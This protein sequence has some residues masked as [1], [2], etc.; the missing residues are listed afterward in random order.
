MII[1]IYLYF[2]NPIFRNI[3]IFGKETKWELLTVSMK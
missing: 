1:S 3:S 2:V